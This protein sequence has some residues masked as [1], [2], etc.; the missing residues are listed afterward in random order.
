VKQKEGGTMRIIQS[1]HLVLLI[2]LF[3]TTGVSAAELARFNDPNPEQLELQIFDLPQSSTVSIEFNVTNFL[4]QSHDFT[5]ADAWILRSTDREVVWQF[6]RDVDPE[7]GEQ[8]VRVETTLEAG[9]YEVYLSTYPVY[10]NDREGWFVDGEHRTFFGHF[11][12]LIFNRDHQRDRYSKFR[13]YYSDISLRVN[14]VGTVIYPDQKEP[15]IAGL[16]TGSLV[17]MNQLRD[18]EYVEAAFRLDKPTEFR[19]YSLG[20]ARRDG[21]YDGGRIV[22]WETGDIVWQFNYGDSEMAGGAQKNRVISEVVR[23]EPGIY[24]VSVMTDDSHSNQKWNMPPPADPLFW[25]L[26]IWPENPNDLANAELLNVA[27]LE[28]ANTVLRLTEVREDEFLSAGFKISQPQKIRI[29]AIG[30]GS[31]GRMFDYGWIL[32][33]TNHE[34]VWTM[35]YFD[36]EPAGG[37]EK[38]RMIN[39]EI[40]L[41]PGSYMV[42]YLS[43]DSHSYRDWN[44]A[45]PFDQYM[46]GITIYSD[47]PQQF[48]A[49]SEEDDKSVLVR[50]TRVGDH[51]KRRQT[52]RLDRDSEVRVYAIGEGRGGEMYDY[53]WIEDRSGK[54]VWEMDYRM[55]EQAGGDRKNRLADEVIHL[56][57]GEY[58]VYYRSD[59]SHSFSEWN[60]DPPYDAAHYGVTVYSVR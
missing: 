10:A 13:S 47:Q 50:M 41:S 11:F 56:D 24:K 22:N 60:A 44:A 14:G 26:T 35:R 15:Y 4:N 39:E 59:D 36:T 32:N 25:G 54:K 42:Y 5:L 34:K 16:S 51:E 31:R 45:P 3:L 46:Y 17:S 57:A 6:S 9:K 19:I 29:Y 58:E 27:E 20:E 30:E 28:N 38:N 33:M 40:T 12:D 43:D 18:D 2:A 37:A 21:V 55:T 53:A 49:Y 48:T 52:F 7:D 23:L 1:L 8:E